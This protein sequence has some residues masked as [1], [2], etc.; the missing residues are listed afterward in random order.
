M[1]KQLTTISLLVVL[2][3]SFNA[4]HKDEEI[5]VNPVSEETLAVN[6]WIKENMELYYLWNDELPDI[7][8]TQEEDPSEYFSKLLYTD[9]SWSWITDDYASLAA[10]FSGVQ[11]TM[12]FDYTAYW[13]DANYEEICFVVDYVYPESAAEVG[14]L[15]RGDVILKVNGESITADNYSEQYSN[16]FSASSCTLQIASISNGSLVAG[17][18]LS[19]T[20]IET[21]TDPAIYHAVLDVDG[22][23]VGYLVYVEYVAGDDDKFL[24]SLDDI[25]TEFKT[26]GITDLIV[27]LRYNPGGEIDAASYLAS[28]IA[29]ASVVSAHETLVKMQ[30][31]SG[32]Q[33]YLESDADFEDYLNY[34]FEDNSSNLNLSTVYFLTTGGTAS[35]SELT[36][37]GLQPYMDVIKIGQATYGKY[38]GMWVM[39]DDNDEWCMLP[40]VMKYANADGYTDFVDGLDPDYAITA[41]SARYPF[42]DT[43][44]PYLAQAISLIGGT[45]T[46]STKSAKIDVAGDRFATKLLEKKR[47]LY[48]PLNKSLPVLN[49]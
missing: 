25:F 2:L 40:V 5:I 22:K 39:P 20:A 31:N 4:C 3:F 18:T 8:E 24:Q 16:I 41:S 11:V 9:D 21:T 27:D 14:G 44:D 26:A 43:D 32:L 15:E 49:Q 34:K 47:N 23:S 12:G 29:P 13:V 35:A 33:A 1:K 36:M 6:E 17:E 38:T 28:A 7:D 19:L 42:G 45:A 37:I 10:E 48:V 30:Y 46:A